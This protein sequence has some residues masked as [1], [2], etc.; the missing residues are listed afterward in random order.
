VDAVE[1]KDSFHEETR[2]KEAAVLHESPL[3]YRGIPPVRRDTV[4]IP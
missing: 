1:E 4:G 3:G 2:K